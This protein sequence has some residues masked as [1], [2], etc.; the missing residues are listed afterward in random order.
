MVPQ[1]TIEYNMTNWRES[2]KDCKLM[3]L[4]TEKHQNDTVYLVGS[5]GSEVWLFRDQDALASVRRGL[6]DAAEGKVSKV[7]LDNL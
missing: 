3:T 2:I 6:V 5:I 1:S 7:D 4:Y